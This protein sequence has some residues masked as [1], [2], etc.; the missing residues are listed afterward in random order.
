M[1]PRNLH[2]LMERT[3]F[4]LL[5]APIEIINGKTMMME[6]DSYSPF[7]HRCSLPPNP[8]NGKDNQTSKLH[9]QKPPFTS[10][11]LPTRQRSTPA[12]KGNNNR[13]KPTFS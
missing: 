2:A 4:M 1:S 12:K 13:V 8:W 3:P 10:I 6:N 9:H 5:P 7:I 11:N